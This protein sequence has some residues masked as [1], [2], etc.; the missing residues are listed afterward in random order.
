MLEDTRSVPRFYQSDIK[1][2]H[3]FVEAACCSSPELKHVT[4][5]VDIYKVA[6]K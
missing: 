3:L 2:K 5:D 6:S 1:V 4:L